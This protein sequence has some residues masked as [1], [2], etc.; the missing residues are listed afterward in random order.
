MN[1]GSFLSKFDPVKSRT[2]VT[3]CLRLA[4]SGTARDYDAQTIIDDEKKGVFR[5]LQIGKDNQVKKRDKVWCCCW[6]FGW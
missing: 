1:S 3:S 5:V 6:Q 2:I 4:G